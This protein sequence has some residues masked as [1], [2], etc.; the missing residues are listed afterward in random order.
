MSILAKS[1]DPV[2]E[3]TYPQAVVDYIRIFE[4]NSIVK[5]PPGT[6]L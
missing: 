1:Y 5:Y 4:Y 3:I 6:P 2:D